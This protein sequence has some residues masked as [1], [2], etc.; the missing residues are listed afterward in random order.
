MLPSLAQSRLARWT[1]A[2]LAGGL[3]A[4]LLGTAWRELGLR[5]LA[6]DW[7]AAHDA[8]D[9]VAMEALHCWDGV[10]SAER[11]RLR[12]A[13]AQEMELH[14]A[15]VRAARLSPADRLTRG[16]RRPN[17]EPVGVLE[18]SFAAEDGLA[19]RILVGRSGLAFR[20]VVLVPSGS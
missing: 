10:D 20:L 3:L 2:A 6:A 15:A 13:L 14:V 11:Q 1:L 17:L 5:S 19:A 8:K 12:L 9:L 18:V 4:F 16:S 7:R